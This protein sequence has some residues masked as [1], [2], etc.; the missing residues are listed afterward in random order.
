MQNIARDRRSLLHD[1]QKR[2]CHQSWWCYA[3]QIT[4]VCEVWS[5]L[6]RGDRAGCASDESYTPRHSSS[7]GF[8][9]WS[10]KAI[11]IFLSLRQADTW[12]R[13]SGVMPCSEQNA[14]ELQRESK[15]LV[16][17]SHLRYDHLVHHLPSCTQDKF[18]THHAWLENKQYKSYKI[19]QKLL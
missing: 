18:Q 2:K 11:T 8:I 13:E 4:Y 17:H 19:I 14:D 12:K 1:N 6:H 5:N 7:V 3:Y 15:D 10:Q 9:T 16:H